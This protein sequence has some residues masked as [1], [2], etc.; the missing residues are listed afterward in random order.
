[1]GPRR[2]FTRVRGV[3]FDMDGTLTESCLDFARIRAEADVPDGRPILEYLETAPEAVRGRVEEVLLRHERRAALDCSLHEGAREVTEE[4]A[5]RGIRT[6]LLTRNSAESV[7]TVLGRF[8]L[9]F[10]C[11]LSREHAEPKPSPRPVLAIAERLA[12]EPSELL[13]VGDYLFDVQSGLAA[14]AWTAFVR[15]PGGLDPPEEADVVIDNL[16][17]LLDLIPEVQ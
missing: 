5:R 7:R 8:G 14:G 16:L 1:M 4:L 10:D 12:L 13:M 6:A 11:W 15:R 3:V 9:S 17:E 2:P